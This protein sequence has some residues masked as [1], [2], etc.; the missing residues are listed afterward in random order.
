[1][2]WQDFFFVCPIH[3]KDKGFCSPIIDKAAVDAKKKREIEAEI[4]RVKQEFEEKKKK[5]EKEKEKEKDTEKEKDK[6][7]KADKK[8][9][10]SEGKVGL[11][12]VIH[13]RLG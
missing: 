4:E 3:L 9:D 7:K 11:S 6:D 2:F 8:E 10:K 5:R 1:M 12:C 13:Q